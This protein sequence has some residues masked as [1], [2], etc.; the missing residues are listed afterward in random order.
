V[1]R[2]PIHVDEFGT[3][4]FKVYSE[5]GDSYEFEQ[6]EN[7]DLLFVTMRDGKGYAKIKKVVNTTRGNNK[8]VVQIYENYLKESENGTTENSDD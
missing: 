1:D 4:R 7:S 3:I 8:E 2:T 6:E 5:E